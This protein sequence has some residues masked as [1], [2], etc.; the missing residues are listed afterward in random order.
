MRIKLPY[1][2][3][4]IQR[5]RS[6]AR[7]H[8]WLSAGRR[9]RKTSGIMS[10]AV[11]D[12]VKGKRIIWGAPTYQQVRIAFDETRRAATGVA[13]F[14]V[15]RM[16][17]VFPRDGSILFRS[18]DDPDNARGYTADGV[19]MDEVADI[20]PSAW[21]EVL[22]P[23]LIDTGGW[24]WG[25]GTPKGRNWFF[26]EHI[27]AMS[28]DDSMAWQAPTVGYEVVNG[29]LIRRPH[30]LENPHVPASE[31]ENLFHTMPE[32]SFRQEI[33]AEFIEGEG[34]VFRNIAACMKA[35]P[36][37]PEEHKGHR[38]VAGC[39][40]AKQHDYT[41]FSFGCVECRCE[42]DNDRFNRID[43]AFQTERLKAMCDR[44]QPMAVLT[45]INS[46]GIP[47][48][49]QVERMGLPV[50][51]FETT[52]V[53]KPPLIE[54][55]AL[56]LEK[57]EWQYL[58]DPVWTAELE[59]YERKVSPQTGRSTYSAPDGVHDDTVI[60]RCLMLWAAQHY[61]FASAAD[62]EFW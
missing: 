60:A 47:V 9:W 58:P 52:A 48:F 11:E 45:E 33:L 38:I 23:M 10:V 18:L 44:W 50:V 57:T 15:S 49:E 4:G 28:R 14:N 30:P 62:N 41:A 17:A 36:T 53:S 55:F 20:A 42:V 43:Y 13:D 32:R 54:N 25:L 40:W 5:V 21:Y 37:T 35:Q 12:A 1:P 39:D 46:I 34:A 6:E 56:A 31:I 59:A 27:A 2:H 61:A 19:V 3:T 8:N 16:E 7:R 51:A 29:A 26:Q 24:S 22:R